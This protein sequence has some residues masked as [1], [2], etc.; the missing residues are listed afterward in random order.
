[1]ANNSDVLVRVQIADSEYEP[2]EVDF[3]SPKFAT[4]VK[5]IEDLSYGG[6][7]QHTGEGRF[8]VSGRWNYSNNFYWKDEVKTIAD[9]MVASV[10]DLGIDEPCLLF[11]YIDADTAMDWIGY[12]RVIV[13]SDGSVNQVEDISMSFAEAAEEVNYPLFDAT[14]V[15][16]DTEEWVEKYYAW[17]DGLFEKMNCAYIA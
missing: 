11:D 4:L 5:S 6:P 9:A 15:D 1:M 14:G 17:Y 12:G 7:G 10:A 3:N 2:I 16:P 13:Y 8:M